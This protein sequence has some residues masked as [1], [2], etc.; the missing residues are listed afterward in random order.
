MNPLWTV[1]CIGRVY[2]GGQST[3]TFEEFSEYVV[4]DDEGIAI[5][6]AKF[7]LAKDEFE[8]YSWNTDKEPC[9]YEEFYITNREIVAKIVEGSLNG[10]H[11]SG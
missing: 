2:L 9:Y 4:Q 8:V 5:D 10:E 6:I 7:L 1:P 11:Q 3:E